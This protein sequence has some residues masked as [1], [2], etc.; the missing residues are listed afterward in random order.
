MPKYTD[1]APV[2]FVDSHKAVYQDVEKF[3]SPHSTLTDITDDFDIISCASSSH[4]FY[5][6]KRMLLEEQGRMLFDE[7]T[8]RSL[9]GYVSFID[10][11]NRNMGQVFSLSKDVW[12]ENYSKVKI[13]I[14]CGGYLME[15]VKGNILLRAR[16]NL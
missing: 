9:T 16:Q 6:G 10:P 14:R 11:R 8:Q 15:S 2:F 4:D 12:K 1:S 7:E 5:E 13:I 3:L